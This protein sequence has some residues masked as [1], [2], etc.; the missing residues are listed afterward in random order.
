ML[1]ALW[2]WMPLWIVRR[3]ALRHCESVA[4]DGRI[5]VTARPDVLVKSV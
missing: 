5:Y 3:M 2:E 1:N 4:L